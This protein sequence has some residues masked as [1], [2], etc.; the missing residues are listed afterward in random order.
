MKTSPIGIKII[1]TVVDEAYALMGNNTSETMIWLT[2][3]NS[4]FMGYS[5]FEIC[6]QGQGEEVVNW[7]QIRLG[8]VKG[9][10]F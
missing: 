6:I 8:K 4:I 9:A 3:P 5:P 7:I 1:H 10:G 2:S